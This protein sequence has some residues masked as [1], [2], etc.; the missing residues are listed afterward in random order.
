MFP[1][2]GASLLSAAAS[3]PLHLLPL[4]VL[5]VLQEGRLSPAQAG[6]VGS[7]YMLG[8]LC[9]VLVLPSLKVHRV[10]RP[11]ATAAVLVLIGA[12]LL[13]SNS[14]SAV[15]LASWLLIGMVCGS[16]QFLATTTAAAATDRR[17]A[18]AFR[19]AMSAMM[20]GTVIV[21]LQLLKGFADY[22]TLSWQLAL[23][24]AA[25]AGAGLVFYRTPPVAPMAPVVKGAAAAALSFKTRAGFA[26]L[27]VLFVG[28]HGLWAF[29]VQGAQQRGLILGQLM[30][31][32]ALCK[33]AGAAVVLASGWGWGQK[34]QNPSVLVPALAV[35]A[36]GACLTMTTQAGVFWTGLLFWE[37]GFGVLSA[38]LQAILA[39]Q[40]PRRAGMWMTSAIFLGAASGPALA[41]WTVGADLFHVFAVFGVATA[42]VPCL[43][44][45]AL[46]RTTRRIPLQPEG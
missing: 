35:A 37:V 15:L 25:V 23:A 8:Q 40:D 24:F 38:R 4:L 36:G 31:A 39:Q 27:F 41:G 11:A 17:L 28:Q 44:T 20:G 30:W 10:V 45:Y 29:A 26:V 33:F 13:S 16:L 12:T 43:W 22:A 42:L 1:V 7:A 2:I 34:Q 3:L 9:A 6:W 21:L 14:H 32:I 19:M 46:F 5:A 18:F